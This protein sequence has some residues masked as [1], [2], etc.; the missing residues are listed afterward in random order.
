[1]EYVYILQSEKNGRYYVGSTNDLNRRLL[2]HNSGQTKSL[3]KLLPMKL[4]F[5]KSFNEKGKARKAEAHLKKLK[6]RVI[7]EKIVLEG[8]I[9]TSVD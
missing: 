7:L 1:M 8:N 5:S 2:E 4:I 6:S 3:K 9:K